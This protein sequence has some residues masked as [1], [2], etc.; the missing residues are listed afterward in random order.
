MSNVEL[1][2]SNRVFG[3]VDFVLNSS[4]LITKMLMVGIQRQSC[5]DVAFESRLRHLRV[6]GALIADQYGFADKK[7]VGERP[8]YRVQA[9]SLGVRR[10]KGVQVAL[11]GSVSVVDAERLFRVVNGVT[12]HWTAPYHHDDRSGTE[13]S[14][15]NRKSFRTG[16]AALLRRA[17]TPASTRRWLSGE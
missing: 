16:R 13:P 8:L 9:S 5:F 11:D 10:L 2:L 4:N 12:C 17:Y 3:L 15:T 6:G 14:G 1:D 7:I